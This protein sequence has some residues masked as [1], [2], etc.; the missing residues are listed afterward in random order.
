MHCPF[1]WMLFQ[2]FAKCV[3]HHPRTSFWCCCKLRQY[4]LQCYAITCQLVPFVS[5]QCLINWHS[6]EATWLGTPSMAEMWVMRSLTQA[7]RCWENELEGVIVTL[8]LSK[9]AFISNSSASAS[10]VSFPS[11]VAYLSVLGDS[12]AG[13][14][15]KL[16]DASTNEAA[17][18]ST[19]QRLAL[20][21]SSSSP[22]CSSGTF[23]SF[24][25][26]SFHSFAFSSFSSFSVFSHPICITGACSIHEHVKPLGCQK[27]ASGTWVQQWDHIMRKWSKPKVPQPHHL[28]H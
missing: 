22:I 6:V 18:D 26:H 4:T 5:K 10:P 23:H 14:L 12:S 15:S 20:K 7:L 25:V 24:F 9:S 16:T 27:G 21:S 8:A 2:W 1:E 3:F 28:A 13:E 17:G 19:G 11:S